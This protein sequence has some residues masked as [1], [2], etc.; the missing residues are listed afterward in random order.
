MVKEYHGWIWEVIKNHKTLKEL[1][2]K[3]YIKY[4][5]LLH[6]VTKDETL[7]RKELEMYG[8]SNGSV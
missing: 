4:L 1:Q 5:H 8:G 6:E 3:D 2:K 7:R